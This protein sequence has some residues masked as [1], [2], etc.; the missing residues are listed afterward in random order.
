M[1]TRHT[2]SRVLTAAALAI[3]AGSASA[4]QAGRPGVA[5]PRV[6]SSDDGHT[7]VTLRPT[8]TDDSGWTR[9]DSVLYPSA[10]DWQLN[11]RRQVGG[12]KIADMNGDGHNDLVIGVYHSSSFP[13]YL[14]W[15]DMIL[16]NT[17]SELESS[18]SWISVDQTH[19][20]DV[21]VGDINLDTYPDFFGVSGVSGFSRV[22]VYFGS[23]SGPSQSSGW[24]GTPPR[25]GWPTSGLLLDVDKDGDLDVFT[26]NQA[27]SPDPTGRCTCGAT[28]T[29]HS[30]PL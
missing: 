9:G 13:E 11:L 3:V 7:T 16:Y 24:F 29:A 12:M 15:H 6:E 10:A 2:H 27:V 14:D 21:Q 18:P 4:Q 22:R 26:T 30:T 17:G 28:T 8:S 23:A 1:T 25:S 5:P 20:G 19:T